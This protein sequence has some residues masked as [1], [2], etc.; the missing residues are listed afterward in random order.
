MSPGASPL[1]PDTEISPVR[2]PNVGREDT[3]ARLQRWDERAKAT[4]T[5]PEEEVPVSDFSA[6]E[7]SF[8]ALR[9]DETATPSGK[10]PFDALDA[11][12]HCR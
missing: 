12:K 8:P 10:Q 9:S 7:L 4:P 3:I 6:P 11:A 1:E 2:L 5:E